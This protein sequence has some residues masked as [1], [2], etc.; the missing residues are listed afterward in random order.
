MSI[1]YR[2]RT[3]PA[4]FFII[5][6]VC[7]VVVTG[8]FFLLTAITD[9]EN[10]TSEIQSESEGES[11]DIP[12]SVPQITE[13]KISSSLNIKSADS[14]P[15]GA[16]KLIIEY[17][18]KKYR[19][20]AKLE[21]TS[22]KEF[23]DTEDLYG[24]VYSQFTDT[25]LYYL[26]YVRKNRT[27][28][29]KFSRADFT[30]DVTK[31]ELSDDIYTVTYEISEAVDFNCADGKTSYSRGMVTEVKI[32]KD[33]DKFL[34]TQVAEDT[35]VN[36]L[37]EEQVMLY[38]G[39]DYDTE[40]LKD[41]ELPPEINY[42]VIF[43]SIYKELKAIADKN[44]A[45]LELSRKEYIENPERY[46]FS[47]NAKTPYD[48]NAAVEYSYNWVSKSEHLRNPDFPDY[49]DYGGNCQ[50]YT[51]QCILA[52]GIPMD[53]NGS[54]KQQWKWF[55]NE[56]NSLNE[57]KGRSSSWS[58]T[59]AFYLYCNENNNDGLKAITDINIY[60]AQK[61][62]VMQYVVDGW[63]HHSVVVTDI[64][65]DASG[66]PVEILINSNTTDRIDYPLTA[67]G[68]TDIR[69]IHIIGC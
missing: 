39:F 44:I 36:L 7:C 22:L 15:D 4:K 64:I 48:R 2:R 1:K 47:D 11:S 40:Y 54:E 35:D 56:P 29:L 8:L 34:F 14:L 6:L 12:V 55:D 9:D 67:Y 33:G 38:L 42:N 57:A 32:K 10:H 49:T 13:P 50:N 58:G 18:E 41:V 27:A 66:N 65:Y 17:N 20:L 43:E 3:S 30:V 19:A 46:K 45:N 25:T 5:T 51:S 63:A 52:G 23:F 53:C 60:S 31:V 59:E 26:I 69:G 37:I 24:D 68:Y 62:D 16:E 28:D 21:F 61:G